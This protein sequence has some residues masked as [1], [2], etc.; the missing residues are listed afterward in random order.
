MR[1]IKISFESFNQVVEEIVKLIRKGGIIA[2]PTDTIYGL[3]A[4]ATNGKAV[5]KVLEIK[6]RRSQKPFPIFAKD[7][8]MTKA[9]A[10]IDR[11]Q[12]KFLTKIW[13][14]EV[15]VVLKQR[16]DCGLP[17]ILFGKTKTIGLRIPKHKLVNILLE[18]IN[19]PLIGTSANISGRPGS[20][21]IKKVLAQFKDKRYQPDLIIDAGNLKLSKPSAVVD[22]TGSDPKILR[23][24]ELSKDELLRILK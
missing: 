15:T 8:K 1:I 14:G 21:E 3:I 19:K 11:E 22:L 13:P 23:T 16:E 5:K 7:I 2:C 10:Q 4:D 9:L 18:K 17:K 12:Q 6:K 20:T 24:G